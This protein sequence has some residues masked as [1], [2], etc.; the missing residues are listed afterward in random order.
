M[1]SLKPHKIDSNEFYSLKDV[2]TFLNLSYAT[3]HKLK[4]QGLLSD[5]RKSGNKIY[6]SGKCILAY[7]NGSAKK[8]KKK[9]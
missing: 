8:D 7:L 2:Q 1:E 5:T 4:Q 3:V 9:A 6:V